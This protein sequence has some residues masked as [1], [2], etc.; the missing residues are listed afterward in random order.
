MQ[1][2]FFPY[3]SYFQLISAVDKFILY[4]RVNFIRHGWENRNRLLLV[5]GHP[6]YF[7]VPIKAGSSNS[8]SRDIIIDNRANWCR[9]T[10]KQIVMNY[11]RSPFFNEV[12]P[13]VEKALDGNQDHLTT[14]NSSRKLFQMHRGTMLWKSN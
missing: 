3:L 7:G 13:L 4:D 10:C 9:K 11:R 8:I 6:V 5:N 12:Y 14:L 2:Y 1:P